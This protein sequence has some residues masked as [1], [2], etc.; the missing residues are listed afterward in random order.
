MQKPWLSF[1]CKY[2]IA[3]VHLKKQAADL[4]KNFYSTPNLRQSE[5][6]YDWVHFPEI[7]FPKN[8]CSSLL[9]LSLPSILS[10]SLPIPIPPLRASQWKI[11]PDGKLWAVFLLA[12]RCG[13]AQILE[14]AGYHFFLLSFLPNNVHTELAAL[15]PWGKGLALQMG[16]WPS[17]PAE[18]RP[19]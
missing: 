5:R 3:S 2:N 8:L 14:K 16:H 6:S 15:I 17:C 18:D 19:L 11:F 9:L 12:M 13:N 4:Y 1:A 10:F 7:S